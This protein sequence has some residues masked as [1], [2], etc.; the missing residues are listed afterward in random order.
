MIERTPEDIARFHA[1]MQRIAAAK[2]AQQLERA[3]VTVR[4]GLAVTDDPIV[5]SPLQILVAETL[6]EA[7]S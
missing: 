1:D 6:C 3:Q 7:E 4:T 2:W 5:L